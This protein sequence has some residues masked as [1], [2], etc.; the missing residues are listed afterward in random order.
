[1]LQRG[2]PSRQKKG[3]YLS[4]G[5]SLVTVIL[6]LYFTTDEQTWIGL[7]EVRPEYLLL[8]LA[9]VVGAWFMEGTRI[10][11]ILASLEEGKKISFWAGPR[12][13]LSAFFFAGIT[14]MAI[15]EWPALIYYLHR[16]GVSLGE[17]TAT[18]VIRSAMTR[19]LFLVLSLVLLV[20]Y[21]GRVGGGDTMTIFFRSALSVLAV[22]SLVYFVIL[23]KPRL[24]WIVLR[25]LKR[26]PPLRKMANSRRL[27][28]I[29]Q[30]LREE[31]EMF[32]QSLAQLKRTNRA[33]LILPILLTFGYWFSYFLVA[34][35]LLVGLGLAFDFWR[36]LVW[37]VFIILIIGYT[38]LP[39]GS[40]IVELSLAA[41]FSRY[42]PSS[43]IGIFVV[44]WRFFTY[45][46]YLMAGGFLAARR[47][48]R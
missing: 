30:R 39:G 2:L 48:S 46:I 9:V 5:F 40:G 27:R 24:I 47:F 10:R 45:Y 12:V 19:L 35:V 28:G 26:V 14:P 41:F 18:M 23:F 6:I 15:G 11:C 3:L 34:P 7:Q 42:V 32:Q 44:S 17:S 33:R 8:A 1:M 31:A 4:L 43:L 37:Q 29:M 21:D 20:A 36:I 25:T 22:T 38:P 16:E 13:F